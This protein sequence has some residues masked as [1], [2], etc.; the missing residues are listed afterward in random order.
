MRFIPRFDGLVAATL[1]AVILCIH[2]QQTRYITQQS[3]V[4]KQKENNIKT[5]RCNSIEGARGACI[6][7][8][9]AMAM[10]SGA[11]FLNGFVKFIVA[12]TQKTSTLGIIELA[13]VPTSFTVAWLL[14]KLRLSNLNLLMTVMNPTENDHYATIADHKVQSD[15]REAQGNFFDQVYSVFESDVTWKA[16]LVVFSLF[17][18]LLFLPQS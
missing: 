5:R 13:E 14:W 18:R 2:T 4:E 1:S 12:L 8:I 6:V 17:R 15:L 16:W 10:C 9:R 3:M 11:L 7:T